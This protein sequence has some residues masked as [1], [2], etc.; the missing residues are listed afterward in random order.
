MSKTTNNIFEIEGK[1]PLQYAELFIDLYTKKTPAP[2]LSIKQIGRLGGFTY[3]QGIALRGIQEVYKRNKNP[4]YNKYIIE[5]LDSTTNEDGIPYHGK[6][7]WLSMDSLDFRQPGNLL[8]DLYKETQNKKYL[9]GLD[10]LFGGMKDFS[11][12]AYGTFFHSLVPERHGHT[13]LDSLYMSGPGCVKYAVLR[14]D[15]E[16][17]D[18]V[19]DMPVTM[20]EHMRDEET[21][22]LRHAWDT[23]KKAEWAD[24]ETGLAGFIWD[25]AMGWYSAAI[26]EMYEAAPKDHKTIPK[27]REI[28]KE[29]FANL[30]KYQT[31]EGRWYQLVDKV[32]DPRNWVDNSGTLLILYAMAKAVN[33]GILGEEYVENIMRG[34]KDVIVN[35]TVITDDTFDILEICEGTCVGE[36]VEYYYNRKQ[37]VNEWHGVAGFLHMCAEIDAMLNKPDL[38]GVYDESEN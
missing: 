22:L 3:P 17:L 37:I 6:S 32:D 26:T 27:I 12:T 35:S 1:T 11:R 18:M 36:N 30:I 10:Y 38:N 13:W 4:E 16:L 9:N 29:L 2:E 5:W 15:E 31:K 14:D 23:T 19:M 25:R 28:I 33:N 34:Y 21:G 20:W 7:G 8:F 24:K